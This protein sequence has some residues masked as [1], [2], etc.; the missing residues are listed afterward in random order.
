MC[1]LLATAMCLQVFGED[2]ELDDLARLKMEVRTLPKLLQHANCKR[3]LDAGLL[4]VKRQLTSDSDC[5]S[6]GS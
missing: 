4:V 6:T 2:A 5:W 3:W 1:S